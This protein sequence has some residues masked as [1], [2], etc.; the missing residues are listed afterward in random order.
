MAAV[1]ATG[2][3]HRKRVR[4]RIIGAVLALFGILLWGVTA[5]AHLKSLALIYAGIT[6]GGAAVV[7]GII[8]FATTL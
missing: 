1:A 6:A 4:K 7:T 8:L 2:S 3:R 5:A